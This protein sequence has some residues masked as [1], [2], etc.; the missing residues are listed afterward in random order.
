M[1]RPSAS[2]KLLP[3]AVLCCAV[4]YGIPP[5]AAQD[6]A[7]LTDFNNGLRTAAQTNRLVLVHFWASWCRPCRQ[8]EA[9]VLSRPEVLSALQG[10]YVLVKID[11]DREPGLAARFGV[12]AVPSDVVLTPRGEIV[13]KSVGANTAE[14]YVERL[15]RV[16]WTW[17]Q[18]EQTLLA[19]GGGPNGP[20]APGPGSP[21]TPTAPQRAA[22]PADQPALPSMNLTI[23]M[24][25]Q[26]LP[27]FAQNPSR[28][29]ASNWS[30]ATAAGLAS[31]GA[32]GPGSLPRPNDRPNP[33]ETAWSGAPVGLPAASPWTMPQAAAPSGSGYAGWAQ[34][35]PTGP[36]ATPS[37]PWQVPAAQPA[38]KQIAEAPFAQAP[39]GSPAVPTP[40]QPAFQPQAIP[41]QPPVGSRATMAGMGG[42]SDAVAARRDP[43]LEIPPGNPPLAMEGYCPVSLMEKERWVLGN[44]RWGVRHEGRTYLFAGPEEQRKFLADPDRY[45]PVSGG[46]D[47]V[48]ALEAG[49]WTDGRRDYGGWFA[50]RVYLFDS[51]ESFRKFSADPERYVQAWEQLQASWRQGQGM[52]VYAQP[53]MLGG[54][55]Q[56]GGNDAGP[57][58]AA[59]APVPGAS[60][61]TPI[62]RY[63]TPIGAGYAGGYDRPQAFANPFGGATTASVTNTPAGYAAPVTSG[64]AAPSG[65]YPGVAPS[66]YNPAVGLPYRNF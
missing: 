37:A 48:K 54:P 63:R 34:P 3:A 12:D 35:T 64:Y 51:E 7:W 23:P 52:P 32:A 31:A 36:A 30:A 22:L 38:P 50:G 56:Q 5:A 49:Q 60:Y 6:A 40:S 55:T 11:R 43:A 65:G 8:M 14:R 24:P 47:I 13:D 4:F 46:R 58:E 66:G 44:R 45:A 27:Q 10:D 18:R 17:R 15:G 33:S 1:F 53:P 28:E 59:A 62:G 20:I 61:Q 26:P 9:E 57:L 25:K 21:G 19:S 29:P 2:R 41:P 42:A 16:A 39:Y